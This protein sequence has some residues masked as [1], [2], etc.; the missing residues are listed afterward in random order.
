MDLTASTLSIDNTSVLSSMSLQPAATL[1]Q[2]SATPDET[3][4][5][6]TPI[7]PESEQVV[8]VRAK[9]AEPPSIEAFKEFLG[10]VLDKYSFGGTISRVNKLKS[11]DFLIVVPSA[12]DLA[13]LLELL[14]SDEMAKQYT[15]KQPRKQD[16]AI[17]IFNCPDIEI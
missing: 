14:K 16:P 13:Y 3:P 12:A 5:P 4:Q 15:F 10:S 1:Q 11:N 8:F 9:S 6:V 2:P 7:T 17:L